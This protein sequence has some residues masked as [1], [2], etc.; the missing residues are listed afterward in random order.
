MKYP[1]V[2][3]MP[4]AVS[5]WLDEQLEARGIDAVVYTR[6]ILSLL[7]SHTVD[8]LYP[9]D[10]FQ[11]T[12]SHSKK[13][14]RKFN[15]G[16]T[17]SHRSSADWWRH[18]HVEA[19]RIKRSAAVE[20][21]LSASEQNCGIESLVDELCD[22]IKN[23]NTSEE[24]IEQTENSTPEEINEKL[25][26]QEQAQKYFAAFPPLSSFS[27]IDNRFLAERRRRKTL[28]ASPI[29]KNSTKSAKEITSIS[30]VLFKETNDTMRA[31][32]Q[33][34]QR[35]SCLGRNKNMKSNTITNWDLTLLSN[36]N[37]INYTG[38]KQK[39]DSPASKDSDSCVNES[40]DLYE[41]DNIF[42]DLPVDIINLL[43]SPR[44]HDQRVEIMN[45]ANMRDTG[46]RNFIPYGPGIIS[47]IWSN[48]E[49]DIIF[50]N[51]YNSS[52][53]ASF[54]IV[55]ADRCRRKLFNDKPGILAEDGIADEE[56]RDMVE[57]RINFEA[58]QRLAFSLMKLNHNKETSGFREVPPGSLCQLKPL[59]PIA[60][61]SKALGTNFINHGDNSEDL[62]NS[63]KSYFKPI[64][65]KTDSELSQP[66]KYADGSTFAIS[67]KFEK[68]NYKKTE[69]GTMFLENELGERKRYFEYKPPHAR[70]PIDEFI[71]R[72]NISE[73][74]KACQ[75]EERALDEEVAMYSLF[76]EM[77]YSPLSQ[78]KNCNKDETYS[79]DRCT[80][81]GNMKSALNKENS[82]VCPIHV[83]QRPESI[84]NKDVWKYE[85]YMCENC[86]MNKTSSNNDWPMG[87]KK[88]LMDWDDKLRSIW[89]GEDVCQK[90]LKE[91]RSNLP[92]PASN[93][94][95]REDISQ[96]GEQLL[97][98][99][100]T[101][102]QS[103]IDCLPESEQSFDISALIS[104]EGNREL[105]LFV[106][107]NGYSSLDEYYI[108]K[109]MMAS[110]LAAATV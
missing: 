4:S 88:Q 25:T 101:I 12:H 82:S 73:N 33:V 59:N 60:K 34:K 26:P 55:N 10:D 85:D 90:C 29:R 83:V 107:C 3:S 30:R 57:N 96:D 65:E 39:E 95:L 22:R 21:L 44:P 58:D 17:G 13:E 20:C 50:E 106:D 1:Q 97:S 77:K 68:I 74:N 49:Q 40:E 89:D 81:P 48:D 6:Y 103:H 94:Q 71:L 19:E 86:R 16:Y 35:L 18:A 75:T 14:V 5:N 80:C 27:P 2:V 84:F 66:T 63:E 54:T 8:V 53:D 47:S 61:P 43:D 9:E 64:S 15:R 7:H 38:L 78:L 70:R 109:H 98:D 42:N 79:L 32:C 37:L 23:V 41:E 24:N 104:Q 46:K 72:Y 36:N 102:Q 52:I 76:G 11:F 31:R 28:C 100:S 110:G 56:N 99:I 93:Q 91:I 87:N 45:I 92:S 69:S 105:S 108:M 51:N 67:N 62:L